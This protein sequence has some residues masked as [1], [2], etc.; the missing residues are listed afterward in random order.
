MNTK[1]I[2]ELSKSILELVKAALLPAL[3]IFFVVWPSHI[4][5][6]LSEAGIAEFEV[7]GI[8]GKT[9]LASVSQQL[10]AEKS[11]THDLE[12]KV[13]DFQSQID[14]LTRERDAS[15]RGQ[16]SSAVNAGEDEKLKSLLSDSKKAL[17]NAKTTSEATANVL[18]VNARVITAAQETAPGANQTWLI[19]FGSDAT[20][21]AAR[22]EIR[23]AG[24]AGFANAKVYLNKSRFRSAVEFGSRDDALRAL[25]KIQQMSPT[26]AQA[27]V[28]NM[29][30][31]CASPKQVAA[32]YVECA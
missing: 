16:G 10:E 11:V 14:R 21:A 1:E 23:K 4:N 5:R 29:G 25:P 13:K 22:D 7:G 9:V 3:V 26:A 2:I 24:N 15:L 32:D 20:V 12:T 31:F 30:L 27:Y 18:S 28:V 6:M 17:E 19:L 8:K